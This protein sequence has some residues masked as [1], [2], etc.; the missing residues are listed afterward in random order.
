MAKNFEDTIHDNL[1]QY[2]V[3]MQLVDK[4]LQECPDVEE[5]WPS[6]GNSYIP[7]GARE[8]RNYPVASLGWMMYIGMAVAKLW[9]EECQWHS[10]ASRS[11]ASRVKPSGEQ[12]EWE[13][14]SQLDDMYIYMRDKRGYDEMDE[15]I[16]EDVLMLRGRESDALEEVVS[17]CAT[18]V[19]YELMRERLEPGTK[20][21]F[22]GYVACLHQLYLF[23]MAMQ[24]HRMGYH[25][26]RVM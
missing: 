6:I 16:R 18:R 9:D 7:D 8:F 23:G 24:L 12:N 26:K 22:D 14:Y 4:R 25:M 11:V 3:G 2:L 20:E 21:A 5:R 13:I 15:F 10:I 17:E 1:H 19:N